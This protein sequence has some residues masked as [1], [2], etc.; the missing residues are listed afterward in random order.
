M[1][2]FR[3]LALAGISQRIYDIYHGV[4]ASSYYNLHLQTENLSAIRRSS[5]NFPLFRES[6]DPT[7][8]VWDPHPTSPTTT[9]I[10]FIPVESCT[11]KIPFIRSGQLNSSSI[12]K[13]LFH[14][15]HLPQ[16]SPCQYG[17]L[18]TGQRMRGRGGHG[19]KP[20]VRKTLL[21]YN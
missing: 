2:R 7:R 3:E 1:E 19:K 14:S 6:R 21:T 10:T 20:T 16:F 5:W 8:A 9:P 17:N 15:V 4:S 12:C 11:P 13:S 18:H